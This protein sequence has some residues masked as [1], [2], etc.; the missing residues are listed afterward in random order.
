MRSLTDSVANL[1]GVGPK[2][3]AD[4]ATL[5]IDTIE[6][7]L[8]YYPTRYND[9]TPTDIESAKDKQK[10]TLQG[11]VVSEPLLVRYGYRRNRLTFRMQVGN[12]VVIATFFNQPYIKKQIELNQQ[13]TVMGK[14]DASR[15]QVTGNK[16]LK[17]K[18]DDR[19]EF[20]AVYAVNKHIRQ[21]VLQSFIRQAYEEYANIIPTYLPETIR[22]RYRLMDRRQMIR[23]IHFPQTQ[24]TAKAARRTAAYEEFFLFQ[25]RLQAIRRAHR[26]EDGERILYHN[27]ELKEFIGGLPFELTDAQKRV[28]NEICRDM[29]QPY[30]MNRLLQGD[31]GSGKTIV[32][33]ITIYAA[34]TAGYQAALM[35][36][37]E[38]LAG[39]HAEKLAKIFEG[40]HVQVALLTGSLTAKQHR[41]LLTAM[42]RGDVN[43]IVGTHAL[44][45]DGV[46]YANLGLVITDEQHRFGVNQ[47]QQLR[48]KGEHPDVLAMTAT[49]IPR[50]LAITN[51][52]EMDVSIIDQLPAG[53][54]PIQT[55]WLQSNQ[56]AAAIHFLREQLKQGAQA[57]VVSPL[58]EESAALDVQNATDLYNQLSADLE[59]AYKVG[60]LHGRMGTE[61]K[62][63]AMRQFK[64][65]ELQ[66]LVAT[67]VIEVGVDNPNATV[68]VIYDAD[69]F[70]L[71]QLHQ[72]RGR[73]GRGSRQSYC[74]LIAD[75]KTDEG[76]ARMK[77][78]V[79]TDDG[80]KIAEQDLKLRGSGD[81]LGKKQ[82]GMPEFKVGDP[83]ADLK[84]LQIARADAGNLLGMPNWDQVDENQPL[85]LYLKRHEL[86]THFD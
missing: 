25:L 48:E 68:M 71:A 85:V 7:L 20:G 73:V 56:H 30:Q 86:E 83:V 22:Q 39:Q 46:E 33:A 5:G 1:K 52:G 31:V 9:F 77:T 79:A 21:N 54:K 61:E 66:V 63:E 64:S 10:I 51:Y 35:A 62:D 16:L 41:E 47:R 80:F 58:I 81:V 26:Q 3:V 45:Q 84:M 59:P 75:P 42:K 60:L 14:W 23:E 72:L 29:R 4:L 40:T 18:A 24:A 12:E 50:T 43:L 82:S 8:T 67:T 37:T 6:D 55:K 57:Y 2:R 32:A 78:M 13:V 69:R 15:R 11:V 27:D 19:N 49:P 74:L 76:K 44:I 38:I 34:I 53:R 65:G 70:G 28:V 36:P 17:G